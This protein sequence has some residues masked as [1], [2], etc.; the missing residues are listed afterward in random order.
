MKVGDQVAAIGNAGGAGGTPSVATGRVTALDQQITAADED[1][2]NAET[3][4]DMI[5]VDANVVPGDSGGPLANT[6]GEVVGMDSAAGSGAGSTGGP[7]RFRG[8]TG[9]GEGYAIPINKALRIVKEL[10]TSHANAGGSSSNGSSTTSTGG[11]L[12][13]QVQAGTDGGAEVVAVQSG[14]PAATAGLAA[15]DT[16]VAVDSTKVATPDALVSALSEHPAGEKVTITWLDTDGRTHQTAGDPRQPLTGR[17]VRPSRSVTW[18]GGQSGDQCQCRGDELVGV[19]GLARSQRPEDTD[20]RHEIDQQVDL[21]M[22]GAEHEHRARR[23][24]APG[25]GR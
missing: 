12:G 22:V 23:G 21:R 25:S 24:C 16:I 2:S 9:G 15:G 1:G 20:A 14:S 17:L 4:T 5:Q 19:A 8:G 7:M 11:F 6:N 18:G 3:L 10:E 13:V